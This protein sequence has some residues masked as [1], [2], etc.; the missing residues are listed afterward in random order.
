[1]AVWEMVVTGF[2]RPC[3]EAN[4]KGAQPTHP[5]PMYHETKAGDQ[6]PK[7][8]GIQNQ[9]NSAEKFQVP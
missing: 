9:P 7:L 1:M 4:P 2:I 5:G 3:W 8:P 6:N